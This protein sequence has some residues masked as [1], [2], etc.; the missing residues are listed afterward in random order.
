M[1]S[2]EEYAYAAG[3]ID[4]EGCIQILHSVLRGTIQSWKICIEINMCSK[5]VLDKMVGLF[6]GN[7]KEY[8]VR[9]NMHYKQYRWQVYSKVAYNALKKMRPYLIEKRAQADLA[10]QFFN[11]QRRCK[12]CSGHPLSASILAKRENMKRRMSELKRVDLIPIALAETECKDAPRG[13]ATVQPN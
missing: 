11:H 2:K 3:I 12:Y 9:P 7:L 10:I 5:K 1:R 6:G 8:G 13:E 4:G